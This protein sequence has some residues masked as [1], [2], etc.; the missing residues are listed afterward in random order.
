MLAFFS[1][2]FR[3]VPADSVL[4]DF[5]SGPTIYSLISAAVSVREIHLCDYLDANLAE[6]GA[7][8]G[9]DQS[10]WDWTDFVRTALLAESGSE[11]LADKIGVRERHIRKC[12]TRIM[13]CDAGQAMPL[14]ESVHPYDV[15]V[16]NFC[17]ESATDDTERWRYFMRN[18]SSLV[19][20]GGRLVMTALKG[21]SSYS[22]GARFFPAV[23][24]IEEDL[25]HA[26]IDA[27]FEPESVSIES[28]PADRPSRKYQGIML[29]IATKRQ[30][31]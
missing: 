10:A 13:R 23:N 26:L 6:V 21:A 14:G 25:R 11:D 31:A 2:A 12:V 18:I 8:L 7:W 30:R 15:V 24:I 20:P 4:L 5:G 9:G 29:A 28:V 22:V 1:R 19:Q 17:A 16:T 3:G 27:G